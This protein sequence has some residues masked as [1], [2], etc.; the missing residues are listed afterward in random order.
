M[1]SVASVL[2]E[3]KSLG[4]AQ[5][6][7][8]YGRHGVSGPMFGVS[9]ANLAKLERRLRGEH[10]LALALWESGIHDARVL[11]TKIADADALTVGQLNAWLKAA[12]NHVLSDAVAE[13]TSRSKLAKGRADV[14]R[15]AKRE[16]PSA[17]GWNLFGRLVDVDGA[18]SA[19]E[20]GAALKTITA[21]I[22]QVPNRT[23]HAMNMALICIGARDATWEKKAIAAAKR[24]G[25]VEVDHGQTGCKT[26][27]AIPYIEKTRAHRERM[28]AKTKP[29]KKR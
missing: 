8:V 27:E 10:A 14:W 28:A 4:T 23:R 9:Y 24:I 15:K 1:T 7:K 13:I 5:N 16:W 12:D 22:H 17:T 2:R 6:R 20:L 19:A 29:A 26:P 11:A 3:L 18:L 21:S 25:T